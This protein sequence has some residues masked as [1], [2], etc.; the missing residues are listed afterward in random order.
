MID[1]EWNATRW[2]AIRRLPM[3]ILLVLPFAAVLQMPN[4]IEEA[5]RVSGHARHANWTSNPLRSPADGWTPD[6]L[7]QQGTLHYPQSWLTAIE[8]YA[9][10]N[11]STI[12]NTGYFGY[13]GNTVEL[14]TGIENLTGISGP[15]HMRFGVDFEK[16]ACSPIEREKPHTLIVFGAV[17]PCKSLILTGSDGSGLLQIYL[18]AP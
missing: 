2:I 5:K 18:V 8:E 7:R 9:R 4:P 16:W 1:R 3:M 10:L 12:Q 17:V 14:I 13:M 6:I 11:A 15:E